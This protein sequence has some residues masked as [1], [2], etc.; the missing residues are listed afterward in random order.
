MGNTR[1][2]RG[3]RVVNTRKKRQEQLA[4]RAV[5]VLGIVAAC[6]VGVIFLCKKLFFSNTREPITEETMSEEDWLG[7]PPLDVELLDV[8][9]YSRPGT[10]LA[11]IKGIVVHYTA[12]PGSSAIANR[13][14]FNGL[15]D[16]HTTKASSHFIVGLDGEIVQCIPSSE[17][18]YASNERNKDTLSIECCHPDETGKF[19]DSTYESLVSLTAW[20]CERFG[21]TSQDVIRHY[22]VTQKLCPK[23]FVDYED[24]WE[25]FKSDVDAGIIKVQEL[26]Q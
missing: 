25:Q 13:N 15:K 8:N 3:K 4:K 11:E 9:E 20:L 14:Y 1:R 2:T 17:I 26:K 18:S 22:D 19:N 16:A 24:A 10:P 5:I 7:A 12:N 6:L 21:L 23:Y